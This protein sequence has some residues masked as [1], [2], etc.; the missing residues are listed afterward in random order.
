MRIALRLGCLLAVPLVAALILVGPFTFGPLW[1]AL[2]GSA[3]WMDPEPLFDLFM[4][5]DRISARPLP[6]P[7][8]RTHEQLAD[9][10]EAAPGGALTVRPG[11]DLWLAQWIVSQRR[12]KADAERRR[13]LRGGIDWP[14]AA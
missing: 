13:I 12:V 2:T 14:G 5:M 1:W 9:A 3:Y 8:P 10:I 4:F 7:P 11:E 6:P